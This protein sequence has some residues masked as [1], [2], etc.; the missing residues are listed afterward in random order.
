MLTRIALILT[1]MLG[2]GIALPTTADATAPACGETACPCCPVDACPCVAP[3]DG[4][5][6]PAA[7][8]PA[9]PVVRTIDPLTLPPALLTIA[10]VESI[11]LFPRPANE[12][13][14]IPTAPARAA[15]CVWTT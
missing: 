11:A 12:A 9:V 5:T 1:L 6:D 7:P 3:A 4:P 10:T 2:G 15:L 14:S 13:L 8:E